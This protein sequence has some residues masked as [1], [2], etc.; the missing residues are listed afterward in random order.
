[1]RGLLQLYRCR[2]T[3]I[4]SILKKDNLQ[5]SKANLIAVHEE[6]K[7]KKNTE[8]LEVPSIKQKI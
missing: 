4:K 2:V 6:V 8:E 5:E 1:M 3:L 7:K